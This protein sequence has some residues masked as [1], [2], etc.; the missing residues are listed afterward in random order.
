MKDVP[1]KSALASSM[2]SSSPSVT[3]ALMIVA[4]PGVPSTPLHVMLRSL[5]PSAMIVRD[6]GPTSCQKGRAKEGDGADFFLIDSPSRLVGCP[7]SIIHFTTAFVAL[8][9]IA[10]KSEK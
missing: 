5:E 6:R 1:S 9:M 2:G 7:C 4:P 8:P 3:A 10:Y